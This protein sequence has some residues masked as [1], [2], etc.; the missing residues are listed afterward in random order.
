MGCMTI[1]WSNFA[2][3]KAVSV[4]L[5]TQQESFWT[6]ALDPCLAGREIW[7][8]FFVLPFSFLL[9]LTLFE[10]SSPISCLSHMCKD[11]QTSSPGKLYT[12]TYRCVCSKRG[13]CHKSNPRSD[14]T[15][16]SCWHSTRCNDVCT[17]V[18]HFL[19]ASLVLETGHDDFIYVAFLLYLCHSRRQSW[20]K[21]ACANSQHSHKF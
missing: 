17:M 9:V 19:S 4:S 2:S 1:F 7:S 12:R 20:N 10:C 5:G 16:K 14:S 3:C 15:V 11:R 21:E 18:M 13:Q 6:K 8:L